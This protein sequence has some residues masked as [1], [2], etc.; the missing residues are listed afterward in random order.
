MSS[1]T[2]G[3]RDL[4]AWEVRVRLGEKVKNRSI[5]RENKEEPTTRE[6]P[7]SIE[8]PIVI[9]KRQTPG[10][11]KEDPEI[12][13]NESHNRFKGLCGSMKRPRSTKTDVI[14]LDRFFN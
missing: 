13:T 14:P 6:V 7:T 5:Q 3:E 9:K 2:D 10:E 12:V 4:Y 8:I 11:R 1:S